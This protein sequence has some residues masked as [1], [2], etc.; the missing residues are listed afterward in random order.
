MANTNSTIPVNADVEVINKSNKRHLGEKESKFVYIWSIVGAL[1]HLY[2]ILI[3]YFTLQV[4]MAIHLLFTISLVFIMYKRKSSE[5]SLEVE[6]IP[7]YD[8]VLSALAVVVN[9]YVIYDWKGIIDRVAKPKTIDMVF[10]ILLLLLILEGC[11]RAMGKILPIIAI[12]FSL[13]CFCGRMIPG[14]LGHHGTSF[15]RFTSIQ[16]MTTEG[17]WSSPVQ[18]SS[19][20]IF[21][22]TL[23]GAFLLVSGAGDKLMEIAVSFAGDKIGG[24][25]KVSVVSSGLM[26][27]VSGSASANVVTTGQFTIP[28]MKKMGFP[29][30]LAGAVEAVA[31]TGGTLAPPVMGAG[32]FIMAETLGIPY[33][34]VVKAAV[35][36]AVL[37]YISAFT[38]VHYEAKKRGLV[39]LPKSELPSR[40]K[41]LKDGIVVILPVITLL[42]LVMTYYPIM[43]AAWISILVL[44]VCTL[45][46]K[47]RIT[48]KKILQALSDGMTGMI[49]LSLCCATAGIVVGC[50]AV[51]G[52][53][54]KFAAALTAL[55]NGSDWIALLIAM[56][57]TIVLGMGLPATAAYV[58]GASIA[59]P[60]LIK[61]GFPPLGSQMFVFYFSCLAQITPPVA[62][63]SYV[64]ASIAKC[65]PLKCAVTSMRLGLVALVIPF[66]FIRSSTLLMQGSP[67]VI[68]W[69][70]F[71]ACL[72]CIGCAIGLSGYFR[73]KMNLVTRI[74]CVFG[75]LLMIMPGLITDTIGII[76]MIIVL[77]GN[78]R[79]AKKEETK[80]ENA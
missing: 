24:P 17:I 6:K 41:A 7:F 67:M 31:S 65:D 58:V 19:K 51:T 46:T 54:S 72:G 61:I 42:V 76:L 78:V 12:I 45:F 4:H 79:A 70:S 49:T 48:L 3:G 40:K 62:L 34:E 57:V 28:M 74:I 50:I 56:A 64:A 77:I 21:M 32:A 55:A 73:Y 44:I 69:D 11:R 35:I 20:M 16:Y 22:F 75:G 26:G 23:F 30:D 38:I 2:S 13:Y 14:V 60:A 36:P 68:L 47:D 27:M 66:M 1:I 18:V 25:G 37:Y 39:G 71:I 52:L 15:K 8:Y 10:A 53:G 80:A 9:G 63:A 29:S 59:A 43:K 5:P 33:L